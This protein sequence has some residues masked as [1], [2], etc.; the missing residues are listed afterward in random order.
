MPSRSFV[1]T[2]SESPARVVVEDVRTR[3]RVVAIDVSAVGAEI[4][5]CLA[6]PPNGDDG[7][8]EASRPA[9]D[10]A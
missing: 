10:A 3:D 7:V 8:G 2:V 9:D 4:E 6:P 5:R 1:V